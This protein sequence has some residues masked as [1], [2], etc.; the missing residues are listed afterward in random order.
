MALELSTIGTK[1]FYKVEATAG[2]FPTS[3]YIEIANIVSIS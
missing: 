1:L 3:S 2:T